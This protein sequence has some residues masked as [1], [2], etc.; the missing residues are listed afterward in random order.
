MYEDMTY[1]YIM[2]QMLDRVPDTMDKREGSV[3]YD[4]LAPAA[5]ELANMY[6]QLDT[7]LKLTFADTAVGEYLDRR[8][9]ERGITRQLATHAVVQ[10][11]FTPASIDVTGKRFNCDEYNYTVTAKTDT[12][13]T[14]QLM[15][16]TPGSAANSVSGQ[17][18]P[19]EYINGLQTA[20]ITG[21][22]IP[23]ED[24]ET[25]NDLRSRYYDTLDSQ[26]FGG[27][28]TDYKN[29]VNAIDGV[30]AVKVTPVWNGGGTV[31]VTIIASDYS[32]PTDTLIQSV[33]KQMDAI[34]PIGHVVTVEGVTSTTVDISASI[35]Y[36]D[37]WNWDSAGAYITDAINAYFRELAEEWANLDALIVRISQ[38]ETRIL[39]CQG[40]L[41]I[42]DTKLNGVA[43]NLQLDSMSI[44]VK[45]SVADGS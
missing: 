28:V 8:C 13:G 10:G 27:N 24:E 22:L 42:S 35:T 11:D 21:V 5:V 25:D 36:Q 26:A 23:G 34:A 38:L 7:V 39:S 20:T 37:G 4:A 6:I 12:P 45:G 29:K 44:P 41:D 31:K 2:E 32:I 9:G 30:G 33:Q 17:L 3:I 16:E 19:I 43:S 15:C 14:Y 18:I 1:E 40:V